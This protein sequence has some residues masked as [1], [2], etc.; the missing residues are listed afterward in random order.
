MTRFGVEKRQQAL[1]QVA[2]SDGR[3]R[4]RCLA[5]ELRALGKGRDEGF[6]GRRIGDSPQGE[7]GGTS[8]PGTRVVEGRDQR[9]DRLPGLAGDAERSRRLRPHLRYRILAQQSAK[10]LVDPVAHAGM[11]DPKAT[12][13]AKPSPSSAAKVARA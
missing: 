8:Y 1:E 2:V 12:D 5:P 10:P 3:E 4:S 9:L 11:V 13:A 6:H 7:R